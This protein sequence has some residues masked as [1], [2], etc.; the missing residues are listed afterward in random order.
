MNDGTYT[1]AVDAGYVDGGKFY[2]LSDRA[3]VTFNIPRDYTRYNQTASSG[4]ADATPSTFRLGE[5]EALINDILETVNGEEDDFDAFYDS[6]W[7]FAGLNEN[8]IVVAQRD[9]VTAVPDDDPPVVGV[10]EITEAQAAEVPS[11][12]IGCLPEQS[13]QLKP[14]MPIAH[15]IRR[16]EA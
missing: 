8:K 15:S 7:N 13:I 1:F 12:C 16:K 4:D 5:L 6:D 9:A 14:R 3:Q 10:T 2:A 11:E